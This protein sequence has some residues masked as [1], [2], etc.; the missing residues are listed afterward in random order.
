MRTLRYLL[1]IALVC[2]LMVVVDPNPPSNLITPIYSDN[3]SFSFS[4]CQPS[5]L[6]GLPSNYVGCFTGENETGKTLTSLQILIPVFDYHGQLDQPGCAPVSQD[7]FTTVTCGITANGKDYYLDF[8][9]GDIPS[10]TS[11]NNSD[12]DCN[13]FSYTDEQNQP[14]CNQASIFTI[15]EAN[16]PVRDFPDDIPV[17]AN[18][19]A[20]EPSS[21]WLLAT[22][23]LSV[24]FFCVD[25]R[26][27]VLCQSRA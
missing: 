18:A 6:D 19:T 7:L 3:F 23:C 16:V 17:V 8:S 20:P 14:N 27:R 24:G 13:Q 11:N 12:C 25:H 21:I 5:Q 22:G 1:A 9:G 2:G 10:A 4:P 26:R 15:A